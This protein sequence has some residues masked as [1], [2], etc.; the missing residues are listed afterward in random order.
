MKNKFRMLVA[1]VT[2][3]TFLPCQAQNSGT[4][5]KIENY[6]KGELEI[7]VAPFGLDGNEINV[8]KVLPDGTI[9]FSW[10]DID[11]ADYESSDFFMKQLKRSIGMNFCHDKKIEEN[12]TEIN[13]ADTQYLYLY[14]YGEIVGSLHP[15]TQ[16]EFNGSDDNLHIGSTISWYYSNGD[17]KFKAICTVY[18]EK[19]GANDVYEIDKNNVGNTTTYDINFKKGWNLVEASLLE[20]KDQKRGDELVITR[21]KE[22]K[23]TINQIP[24]NINWHMK[25]WANDEYLEIEHQLPK[26]TPITKEQYKNW[27]PEKLS[28]LKR[29]VYKI[30]KK[31]ERISSTDNIDLVFEK[32]GE[33]IN[34]TILDCAGSKES[35]KAYTMILGMTSQEWKDDTDT[36]YQSATKMDSVPVIVEY[37]EKEKATTLTYNSNGRFSINA[38]GSKMDPDELWDYLKLLNLEK[39]IE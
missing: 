4:A 38:N 25:Y 2:A 34:V 15:S 13:A 22:R 28:N 30:G 19:R 26:Q 7:K 32:G 35:A 16:K 9:Q 11:L 37:N 6:T 12:N 21:F 23:A 5:P 31:L 29:T 14:K 36:G 20:L 8:G 10:P 18:E 3:I 1:I 33:K 39:L 27:M 17:G 24:N